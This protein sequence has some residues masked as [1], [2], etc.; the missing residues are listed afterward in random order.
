VL[1]K[2]LFTIAL[3]FDVIVTDDV[4]LYDKGMKNG[5]K[6]Y[7]P[8]IISVVTSFRNENLFLQT[9]QYQIR[10]KVL[11]EYR[12]D[13]QNVLNSFV[14]SQTNETISSQYVSKTTQHP[15]FEGTETISG[16]DYLIYSI[17][18]NWTFAEAFVG[19]DVAFYIKGEAESTYVSIPFVQY[20]P[21]HDITYVSN[22]SSGSS[23]RLTNDTV[24]YQ[25][26]LIF[27]NTKVLE[28]YN[29]V[30][31]NNYN[32]VYDLKIVTGSV[33]VIKQL[34][35]KKGIMN[36]LKDSGLAILQLT[37][38][39]HYPRET[40]T[41]DGDVIPVV[42]FSSNKKKVI[43]PDNRDGADKAYGIATSFVHSWSIK[44]VKNST[45]A[46]TK[47]EADHYGSD[48]DTPY[49]LVVG[50]NSYNVISGEST[51]SYTETGD[52]AIEV[53]FTEVRV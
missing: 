50:S 22:Q 29:E 28:L 9:F 32:T 42:V 15:I 26:P 5:V 44:F 51:E 49:T 46:W 17:V 23:Y 34:V 12:D 19:R 2:T 1:V 37:F 11:K 6:P 4:Q 53:S 10:F 21:A 39:T 45:T 48:L 30:N 20:Q 14:S 24:V 35:L 3:T 33:E 7:I 36:V 52:M 16:S 8:A 41:L 13:F 47:L 40:I 25:M 43:D 38:E 18:L 27:S 31:S